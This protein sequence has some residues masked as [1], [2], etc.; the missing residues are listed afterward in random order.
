MNTMKY[1]ILLPATLTLFA[2]AAEQKQPKIVSVYFLEALAPRDTTSSESFRKEFESSIALGL[3]LSNAE[4]SKC[5]YKI[6]PKINLYNAS[7]TLQAREK[8]EAAQKEGAWMIVGPRRS[9]HYLLVANGAPETPSV[10]LMA[11]ASDI[12]KLGSLHLSAYASNPKLAEVAATLAKAATKKKNK[13]KYFSVVS[14]DC[15]VCREFSEFFDKSATANG[16]KKTG[17]IKV[18]GEQPDTTPIISAIEIVDADIV[19]VP[20]YSQVSVQIISAIQAK[21]P[22]TVFIGGDGW[23]DGQFGFMDKNPAIA[24]AH[25]ITIRGF[26]PTDIGLKN[27]PLGAAALKEKD[28]GQFCPSSGPGMAILR[29][30]QGTKDLL[31]QSKPNKKED[32]IKSFSKSGKKHFTAPWGTSAY[33]LENGRVAYWKETSPSSG[34]S[35]P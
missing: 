26:P 3:Q 11:S 30:I 33:K 4:L 25:G 18:T 14:E 35:K 22:N 29:I 15:L 2:H 28:K 16:L 9:N 32:F 10:S 23:G 8:A 12:E 1:L 20:N 17:E 24:L 27:F 31:C 7:D 34:K 5:G 6:E 13:A 21:K 19:L